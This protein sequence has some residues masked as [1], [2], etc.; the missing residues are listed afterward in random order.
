ML[1]QNHDIY[2]EFPEYTQQIE[3]LRTSNSDFAKLFDEYTELNREVIRIEQLVE[4]R[5]HEF[6]ESLKKKRLRAKDKI[7]EY[8]H[9]QG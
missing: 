2:H 4:P 5:S 6:H 9:E 3:K 8:F 7:Y 1:G